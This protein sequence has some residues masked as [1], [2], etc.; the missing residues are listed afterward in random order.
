VNLGPE[1]VGWRAWRV[2]ETPRGLR[3]A[4]VL[5]DD[6]WEPG[7]EA[8]ARCAHHDAPAAGCMCG[9]HAAK[10]RELALPYLVGRNDRGTVDRVLGLVALY[11]RV[12]EHEDGWRA[13][14]AYPLRFWRSPAR[15]T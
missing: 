12:I 10:D 3:L 15:A 6:V 13:E 11:G 14:K 2:V 5:Y 9:F 8:V 7:R 1:I 4:S